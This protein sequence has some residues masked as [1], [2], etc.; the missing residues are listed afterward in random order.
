MNVVA[1]LHNADLIIEDEQGVAIIGG[2][3]YVL[4]LGDR[5]FIQEVIDEQAKIYQVQISFGSAEHLML[6]QD[7]IQ[8]KF[9]GCR[10]TL[11]QYLQTCTVH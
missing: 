7:E 6:H 11:K 4:S 8:L 9:K 2:S 5:V 3:H 10:E 1:Y